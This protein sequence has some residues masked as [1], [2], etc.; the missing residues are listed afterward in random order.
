MNPRAKLKVPGDKKATLTFCV[1]H[2]I[3]CA[4]EAIADHDAFYVALSGGS[5]PKAIYQELAKHS[6]IDW[7]K[8]YL[9]WSDE[10][11][12]PPD[13]EESNYHMAMTSGLGTVPVTHVYRM[14]PEKPAEEYEEMIQ[15][16]LGSNPFDLIMLGMGDDGHTASL[17]PNTEALQE[18]EKL[19]TANYVPQKKTWRMTMTYACI[20]QAKHLAI[21][22]L[23]ENK[24]EM[25]KKV[26]SEGANLPSAHIGTENN[27]ALW[28]A[29]TAA[30]N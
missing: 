18:K 24:K 3:A 26:L 15:K 28:I 19:I 16:T 7:S 22:V 21:Y 30:T 29:D 4:K 9:F 12:V 27:P 25:L 5:T 6:E 10:R 1:H 14:K 13:N 2:W 23:G 17:F 11:N 20:N 8:V